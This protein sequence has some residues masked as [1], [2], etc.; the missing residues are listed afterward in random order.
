MST[1]NSKTDLAEKPTI[2]HCEMVEHDEDL[3]QDPASSLDREEEPELIE[4]TEEESRRVRF[5][6]DICILPL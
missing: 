2:T 5:K 3:K 4:W 6:M 1:L